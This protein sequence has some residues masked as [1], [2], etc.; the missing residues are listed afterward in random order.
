MKIVLIHGFN[1]RDGGSST[2][3]RLAPYLIKAGHHCDIDEADYGWLGLIGVR[4]RKHA[5]VRRISKAIEKADVII[6]HS[7][8]SNYETKA[9]KL[10]QTHPERYTIIRLSPALNSKAT[11]PSNV[12][13]GVVMHTRSD[14]IVWLAGWM[15]AHPWGRQGW[16]GYTG[17]NPCIENRD[18]SDLVNGHS[19]WFSDENVEFIAKEILRIMEES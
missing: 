9:L 6:S 10:H 11:I 4:L 16:Q 3:D 13:R 18:F 7:N 15:P 8:G 2:V 14:F 12:K 5:A 19:D 1:V 17:D